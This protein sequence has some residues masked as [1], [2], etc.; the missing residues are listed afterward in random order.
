MFTRNNSVWW[1][2]NSLVSL[3]RSWFRVW[4]RVGT[5]TTARLWAD[6]LFTW[7]NTWTLRGKHIWCKKH[8]WSRIYHSLVYVFTLRL[9][10]GQVWHDYI[11][12]HTEISHYRHN[13]SSLLRHLCLITLNQ[14]AAM[15]HYIQQDGFAEPKDVWWYTIIPLTS[16]CFFIACH[17]NYLQSFLFKW[18]NSSIT[19]QLT[20]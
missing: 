10:S 15:C 9:S 7:E 5:R 16:V 13:E 8:T 17:L 6:I 14:A 19:H 1:M 2:M 20:L 4:N 11:L 18:H 12:F 3:S